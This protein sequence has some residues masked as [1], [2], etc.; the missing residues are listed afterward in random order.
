VQNF[1]VV[2]TDNGGTVSEWNYSQI[3]GSLTVPGNQM[4]QVGPR[5]HPFPLP[6]S[7]DSSSGMAAS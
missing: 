4:P 1:T 7:S 6:E 2:P 3:G 5:L